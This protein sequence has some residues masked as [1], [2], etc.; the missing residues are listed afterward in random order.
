MSTDGDW[1]LTVKFEQ[2]QHARRLFSALKTHGAAALAADKLRHGLV[3]QREG[4]WLRVYAN[5]ADGLRRA[6]LTIADALDT[7]NVRA[8]EQAEHRD[9][10]DQPWRA[11]DAPTLPER[12]AP[13]VAEHHGRGPWGSE[14]EPNRA[15]AH[16]ELKDRH[17]AQAFAKELADDGYDVH[18]AE[19]FVFI[20]ADDAAAAHKLGEELKLR[21]PAN[22]QL[23]F[24][25][26]GRTTFFI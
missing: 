14:T 17:A 4:A 26:E 25:G 11:F 12:D 1:R 21:A 10:G 6:Q 3:A 22:A 5:S 19:S 20:F 23:F 24:A 13:L 15:Q 18:Q 7:E 2:E 16:F 8:E 9:G